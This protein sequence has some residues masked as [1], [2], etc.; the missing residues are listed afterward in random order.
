MWWA[1]DNWY[2]ILNNSYICTDAIPIPTII[3]INGASHCSIIT[4]WDDTHIS[5]IK[6]SVY[7]NSILVLESCL[8]MYRVHLCSLR[9]FSANFTKKDEVFFFRILMGHRGRCMHFNKEYVISIMLSR[10]AKHP[11]PWGSNTCMERNRTNTTLWVIT[12]KR[13]SLNDSIYNF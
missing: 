2:T 5:K 7:N 10:S 11:K 4:T 1:Q 3:I 13:R 8:H 9:M 6:K 12:E